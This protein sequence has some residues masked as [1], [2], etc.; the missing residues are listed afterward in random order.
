[1]VVQPV[2]DRGITGAF[3]VTI[4]QEYGPELLI[5]SKKTIR[6][7]GTAS[8]KAEVRPVSI[9]CMHTNTN[10]STTPPID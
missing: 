9:E 5:H 1:M 4:V 6:G 10:T 7:H 3:E 8:T 2:K